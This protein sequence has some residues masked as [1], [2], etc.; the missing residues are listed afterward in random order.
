MTIAKNRFTHTI[1]RPARGRRAIVPD[2]TPTTTNSVHIPSENT[3]KYMN[4]SAALFVEA[5][6]VNTAAMTGAEQGAATNPESAP[7]ANAPES[8]PAFPVLVAHS[9]VELGTRIVKMSSMAAA[10][11]DR[12]STRL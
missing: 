8:R 6:Q 2:P 4:P 7:I 11:R 5:T 10:A 9:S 3:N 12:K 1:H